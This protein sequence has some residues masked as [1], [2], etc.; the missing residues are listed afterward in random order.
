[1]V[2]RIAIIY[3]ALTASSPLSSEV[4]NRVWNPIA[5]ASGFDGTESA[6]IFH[7]SDAFAHATAS[8]NTATFAFKC[9]GSD[10]T[11]TKARE[12]FRLLYDRLQGLTETVN[13]GSIIFA[14]LEND[15]QLEPEPET[16]YKAHMAQFSFLFAG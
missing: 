8:T 4:G 3:D 15:F 16:N 1:M 14:R 13:S 10:N 9:Y 2:D 6:I 7:Q 11:Y 12:V 5:P